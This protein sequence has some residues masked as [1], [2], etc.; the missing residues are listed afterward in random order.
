MFSHLFYTLLSYHCQIAQCLHATQFSF[1]KVSFQLIC[2][3]QKSMHRKS[4]LVFM[5]CLVVVFESFISI[6]LNLKIKNI[7][8]MNLGIACISGGLLLLCFLELQLHYG[9][10]FCQIFNGHL[11]LFR[12]L[13]GK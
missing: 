4:K 7:S 8:T 3:N 2:S 9:K 10:E 5:L 12:H 13:H 11:M 6:C 1:C